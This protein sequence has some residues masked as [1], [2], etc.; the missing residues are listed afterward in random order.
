MQKKC[1][2]CV[3]C[4]GWQCDDKSRQKGPDGQIIPYKIFEN[5]FIDLSANILFWLDYQFFTNYNF[6]KYINYLPDFQATPREGMLCQQPTKSAGLVLKEF[7]EQQA[8][9]A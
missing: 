3:A 7:D 5:I 9:I 2:L 8:V 4:L 6:F 1:L